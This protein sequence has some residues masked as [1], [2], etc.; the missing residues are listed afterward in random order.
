[1]GFRE[2]LLNKDK[3]EKFWSQFAD[4]YDKDGEYVVGK[5]I[6]QAIEEKLL[7]EKPFGKAVEFGCGTGYF[8]KAIARNAS[9]VRATDLSDK[10]IEVARVRLK[11]LKN[12][13]VQKED[14]ASTS[15]IAQSFDSVILINLIHVL[16][17]P[18]PCLRESQR[19]LRRGG[20]LIAADFTGFRLSFF[21]KMRLGFRYMK[22]WGIPPRHGKNN[23]TPDEMA[24]LVE[25]A[26]FRIENVEFLEDGANTIF[27][28]SVT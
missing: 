1:V 10:M 17:N 14:C 3:E 11:E 7:Q 28:S 24:S 12:V 2:E 15:F 21:K 20:R 5:P 13:T 9:H 18:S 4:S 6:V 25:R 16:D 19:I 27:L 26:G 22:K 8:T 23:M